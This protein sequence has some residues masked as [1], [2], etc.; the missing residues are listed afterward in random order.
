MKIQTLNEILKNDD[1]YQ[2]QLKKV[3]VAM[4]RYDQ[5]EF[6]E[7]QREIVDTIVAKIDELYLDN[8]ADIYLAGLL[9]GY[10]I[11]KNFSLTKE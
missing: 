2:I 5:T 6:S 3:N 9:D 1:E 4:E 8:A 10:R 11:L 7:G